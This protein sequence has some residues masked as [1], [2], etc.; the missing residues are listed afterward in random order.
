M[1][2]VIAD[3][4]RRFA[5][6]AESIKVFH[7]SNTPLRNGVDWQTKKVF[8]IINDPTQRTER[9]GVSTEEPTLATFKRIDLYNAILIRV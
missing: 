8:S 7:S 1:E 9:A 3:N 6:R 4:S 2:A 5:W